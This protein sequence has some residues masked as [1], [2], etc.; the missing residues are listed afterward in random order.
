MKT[1]KIKKNEHQEIKLEKPGSYTVELRGEGAEVKVVAVFQAQGKERLDLEVIIHHLAP[2]TRA[3]TVMK[4][5]ARDES[6]MRFKGKIIIAKDCGD[7]QSFLT[8]RVL[9][10]SPKAKAEAVPDLEILSSD[11]SCSHAA[12]VSNIPEEQL[13]YLQARGIKRKKAEEMIVEGFLG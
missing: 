12:S 5:V 6:Y 9:L 2:H 1:F 7:S 8:E 10:L 13:F 4:G 11:V 3:E